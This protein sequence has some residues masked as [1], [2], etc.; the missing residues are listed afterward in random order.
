MQTDIANIDTSF[1]LTASSLQTLG[2]KEEDT[3]AI[4]ELQSRIQTRNPM[5]VSEF[6]RDVAQHTASFADEMLSQVNNKEL[7]EAGQLL[8]EVV[9]TAR[10]VSTSS[11]LPII[12]PVID[13]LRNRA[14][15]LMSRYDS[16]KDQI[17]GLI[18]EVTN[19]QQHLQASNGM[20]QSMF[21]N[22]Q[23]EH[24]L[25]GLHVAAGRLRLAELSAELD[26]MKAEPNMSAA[27]VQ[28]LADLTALVSN[29]DKRVGDFLVLQQ[30]ALQSMPAIRLIQ[31]NNQ[32]LVDKLH[33]IREITIPAWKRQFLVAIS[34]ADQQNA[35]QL[36]DSIDDT[37]NALLRHNADQLN[38]N[39]IATAK[40]NQRQVIDIKTLEHVQNQLVNT[41]QETL[42]I[43]ADGAA[44]RQQ[45][46]QQIQAMQD[47]LRNRLTGKGDEN[48][49]KDITP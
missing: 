39:A 13:K 15:N 49:I 30:S 2:L 34:L 12:G 36:A 5:S 27:R 21:E 40:A 47:N 7:A 38:R 45:T 41:I 3:P 4:I 29:L 6:G 28:E 37:T 46:A 23:G 43:Q 22:V 24:R 31:E 32:I 44:K 20:L 8:S 14:S 25:L 18:K 42:K 19:K 35:V 11:S 1:N 17:D 9:S 10:S 48:V 16:A 33:T 26:A